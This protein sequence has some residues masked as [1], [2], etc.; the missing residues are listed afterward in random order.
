MKRTIIFLFAIATSV[1]AFTGKGN[2]GLA[3]NNFLVE[4]NRVDMA[5][6]TGLPSTNDTFIILTSIPAKI[7]LEA[8]DGDTFDKYYEKETGKALDEKIGKFEYVIPEYFWR[9]YR[10]AIISTARDVDILFVHTA[11]LDKALARNMRYLTLPRD[12]LEKIKPIDMDKKFSSLTSEEAD[13]FCESLKGKRVWIIDRKDITEDKI[14]LVEATVHRGPN[15]I[16][17]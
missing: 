3:S 17:I 8:R 4:R 5:D 15:R 13:K 12:F 1:L 14:T 7:E 9:E 11:K 6:T 16:I 2:Q 10:W